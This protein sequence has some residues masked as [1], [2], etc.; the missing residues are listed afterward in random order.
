MHQRD[1]NRVVPTQIGVLGEDRADL[2]AV[3]N[4]FMSRHTVKGVEAK[5]EA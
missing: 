5:K 4:E 2:I 3:S 1:P